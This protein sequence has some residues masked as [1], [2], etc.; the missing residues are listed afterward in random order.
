MKNATIKGTLCLS[1][2]TPETYNKQATSENWNQFYDNKIT[3]Y[4]YIYC[5]YEHQFTSSR[6]IT[7]NM[8]YIAQCDFVIRNLSPVLKHINNMF[9]VSDKNYLSHC[10]CEIEF[11]TKA[12]FYG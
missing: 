9:M 7:Q 5:L 12:Q 3:E 6:W 4:E 11:S 8:K 10:E 1:N 2:E